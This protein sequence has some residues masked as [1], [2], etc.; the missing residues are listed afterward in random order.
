MASSV[1][2]NGSPV[3]IYHIYCKITSSKMGMLEAAEL[4]AGARV[5][6]RARVRFASG[7]WFRRGLDDVELLLKDREFRFEGAQGVLGIG[8]IVGAAEGFE[9]ARGDDGFGR[10]EYGDGTF[11]QMGGAGQFSGIFFDDGGAD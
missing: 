3:L 7:G 6:R 9:G 2:W 8:Q 10:A 5:W 11:Q 1:G 4:L